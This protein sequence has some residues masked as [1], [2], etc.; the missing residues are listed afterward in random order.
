MCR[1][2]QSLNWPT[3]LQNEAQ[4]QTSL[5]T[6]EAIEGC[7]SICTL[8]TEK[9]EIILRSILR[10]KSIRSLYL[11][12]SKVFIIF[13][14]LIW[15]LQNVHSPSCFKLFFFCLSNL[16]NNLKVY[17][18][19]FLYPWKESSLCMHLPLLLCT[20]TSMKFSINFPSACFYS[21]WWYLPNFFI[22]SFTTIP[23]ISVLSIF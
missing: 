17:F 5:E 20:K 10:L 18:L 9:P 19:R 11:R 2:V 4:I 23:R 16:F 22:F 6:E 3:L 7:N 8:T 1:A 21:F 14:F 13:T 15:H 12:P